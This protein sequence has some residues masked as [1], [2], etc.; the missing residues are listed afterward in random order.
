MQIFIH[1]MI[2]GLGFVLIGG[3]LFGWE[4]RN[5]SVSP[6]WAIPITLF[7]FIPSIL[8]GGFLYIWILEQITSG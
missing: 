5:P 1:L 2:G 7:I 8:I 6:L 3:F 4:L